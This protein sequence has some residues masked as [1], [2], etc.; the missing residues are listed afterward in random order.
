[1]SGKSHVLHGGVSEPR[2]ARSVLNSGRRVLETK[3]REEV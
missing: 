1:M 3:E 2:I